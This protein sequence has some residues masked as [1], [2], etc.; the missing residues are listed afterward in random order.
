MYVTFV[1]NHGVKQNIDI[2]V[3]RIAFMCNRR[4][5]LTLCAKCIHAPCK[6]FTCMSMVLKHSYILL[7]TLQMAVSLDT[8]FYIYYPNIL[9][10]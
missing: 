3:N 4:K 7:V 8:C 6:L 1:I 9:S 2:L 5:L 10:L